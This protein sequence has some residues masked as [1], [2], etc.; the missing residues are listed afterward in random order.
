MHY[1]PRASVD[2]SRIRERER[3]CRKV[4]L[5]LICFFPLLLEAIA[6]NH[7]FRLPFVRID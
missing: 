1:Y 4:S 6:F 5:S 2:A 7:A 3:R